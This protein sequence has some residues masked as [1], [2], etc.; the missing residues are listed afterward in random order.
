MKNYLI[1]MKENIQLLKLFLNHLIIKS[2]YSLVNLNLFNSILNL[3]NE[4]YYNQIS[5]E[6][7]EKI[8]LKDADVYIFNKDNRDLIKKF[9]S[10]YNNLDQKETNG[11][12]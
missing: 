9:I 2:I 10:F 6:Y 3:I 11:L 1:L 4:Y 5:R 7:A 8:K 12:N